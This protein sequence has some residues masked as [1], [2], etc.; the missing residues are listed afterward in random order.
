MSETQFEVQVESEVAPEADKQ[1]KSKKNKDYKSSLINIYTYILLGIHALCIWLY[2]SGIAVYYGKTVN[3]TTSIVMAFGILKMGKAYYRHIMG[4]CLGIMYIVILIMLIK[5]FVASCGFIK[6]IHNKKIDTKQGIFLLSSNVTGGIF[7]ILVFLVACGLVREFTW[8]VSASAVMWMGAAVLISS[9]AVLFYLNKYTAKSL[10]E[11]LAYFTVFVAAIALVLSQAYAPA[12]EDLAVE[13]ESATTL[14]IA[15][16]ALDYISIIYG[17]LRPIVYII[18][19]VQSLKCL[20]NIN[21]YAKYWEEKMY[22]AGRKVMISAIVLCF[23]AFMLYIAE[24]G[25]SDIANDEVYQIFYKL[26]RAIENFIP[27]LFAT[28]A[29]YM[30]ADFPVECEKTTK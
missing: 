23:V 25:S 15:E 20:Q 24:V 2:I 6:K 12:I 3:I 30:A 16:T 4:S 28:I 29:M 17:L 19:S 5:G 10:L 14:V 9:R 22:N 8:S 27:L 21:D 7:R 26:Y 11:N 13:I 1:R 18:I